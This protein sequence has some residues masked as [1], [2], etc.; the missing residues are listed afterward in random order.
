MGQGGIFP[1][2][3]SG[4]AQTEFDIPGHVIPE[5]RP[6]MDSNSSYT[7]SEIVMVMQNTSGVGAST[8][9]KAKK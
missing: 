9:M 2:R 7:S 8:P 4:D 3:A 6:S 5:R 1:Q